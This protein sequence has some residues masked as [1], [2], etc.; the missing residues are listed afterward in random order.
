MRTDSDVVGY[1]LAWQQRRRDTKRTG[2]QRSQKFYK[3]NN[4]IANDDDSDGDILDSHHRLVARL[5][6]SDSTEAP[7]WPTVP[8]DQRIGSCQDHWDPN[9]VVSGHDCMIV[10]FSDYQNVSHRQEADGSHC[11]SYQDIQDSVNAADWEVSL[12]ATKSDTLHCASFGRT[13]DAASAH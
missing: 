9:H 6:A 3:L 2:T 13:P 10:A 11:L 1:F 12:L 5:G 4:D 7:S 8:G